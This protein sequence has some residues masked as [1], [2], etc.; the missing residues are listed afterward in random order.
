MILYLFVF[1]TSCELSIFDPMGLIRR[2]SKA[3]LPIRLV[4]QMASFESG[5][6]AFA[7]KCQDR[8]SDPIVTD[9]EFRG[10]KFSCFFPV[11]VSL[12]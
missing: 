1:L 12:P 7:F 8:G 11:P 5:D 3:A 2:G 4:F 6:G 10:L 9:Q